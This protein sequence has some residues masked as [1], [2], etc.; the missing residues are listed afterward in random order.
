[1]ALENVGSFQ[2]LMYKIFNQ[3]S[4]GKKKKKKKKKI[5]GFQFF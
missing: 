2:Y 5:D 1:M 3:I 4:S